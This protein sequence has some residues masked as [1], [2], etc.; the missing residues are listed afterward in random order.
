MTHPLSS[1]DISIF[2]LEISEFCYKDWLQLH[3]Y[4]FDQLISAKMATL[5]L[6]EIN[7]FWNKVYDIINFVYDDVTNKTLSRDSNYIVNV[8]R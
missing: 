2:S 8:V 5:G 6:L 7:V 3:V 1:V 4:N